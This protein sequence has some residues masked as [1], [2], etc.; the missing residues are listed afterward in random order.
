MRLTIIFFLVLCLSVSMGSHINKPAWD[1]AVELCEPRGGLLSV[2]T[3]V[4]F[5]KEYVGIV[6]YC[7]DGAAIAKRWEAPK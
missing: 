1:L 4:R 3:D 5:S 2:E 7:A 6:A